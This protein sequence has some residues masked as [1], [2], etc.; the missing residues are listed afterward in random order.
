MTHAEIPT[1]PDIDTTKSG[2]RSINLETLPEHTR[3]QILQLLV[4]ESQD[5]KSGGAISQG[6]SQQSN[7]YAGSRSNSVRSHSQ[8]VHHRSTASSDYN[9]QPP[10]PSWTAMDS[11]DPPPTLHTNAFQPYPPEEGQ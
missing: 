7:P 3:C 1:M 6:N 4:S 9:M 2:L 5:N 11:L 10:S 8:E